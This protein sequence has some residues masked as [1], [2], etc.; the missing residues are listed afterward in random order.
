MHDGDVGNLAALHGELYLHRAQR[1]CA[2]SP[3]TVVLLAAG[4]AGAAL[5]LG[6]EVVGALDE[7]APAD[8]ELLDVEPL[9]PDVDPLDDG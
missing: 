8:P 1:V 7:A 6:A 5:V 2:T 9:V 3:V 4:D